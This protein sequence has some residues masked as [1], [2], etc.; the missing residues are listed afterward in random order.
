MN[1]ATPLFITLRA[2]L[3]AL[4]ARLAPS[5]PAGRPADAPSL[6]AFGLLASE[7]EP[8]RH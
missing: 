7:V 5:A 1:A 6:G 4:F 2:A 8:H 3:R